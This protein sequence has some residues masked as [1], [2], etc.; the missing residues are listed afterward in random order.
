MTSPIISCSNTLLKLA[1]KF[2]RYAIIAGGCLTIAS[3]L[4]ISVDVIVRKVANTSLGAADELSSYAFAI[5]TTWALAYTALRRAN[6]RVDAIYQY[7]PVRIAAVIDWFTLV[8]L[9]VFMAFLTWYGFDVVLSSWN[10][11]ARSNTILGTP[12][13]IPQGLWFLGLLWMCITLGLMLIRSSVALVTGDINVVKEICG[14][15]SNQDEAEEEAAAGHERIQ[16]HRA[17]NQGNTL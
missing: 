14:I 16:A 2:S 11:G 9:G 5:S 8:A 7:F 10:Q 3:I 13:W 12:L 4:L 6:V 15:R 1:D 17:Q